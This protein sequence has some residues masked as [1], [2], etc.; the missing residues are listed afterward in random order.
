MDVS[1]QHFLSQFVNELEGKLMQTIWNIE[2]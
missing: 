2:I 1:F